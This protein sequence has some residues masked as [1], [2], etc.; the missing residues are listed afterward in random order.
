MDI[1]Y[2]GNRLLNVDQLSQVIG[3]APGTIRN[4][5][6]DATRAKQLPPRREIPGVA[7]VLFSS[8][9]VDKWINGLPIVSGSN[10]RQSKHSSHASSKADNVVNLPAK[11][12]KRRGRPT[13]REAMERQQA[14]QLQ[15]FC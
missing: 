4:M 14:I 9:D 11:P 7:S 12:A 6:S 13:I 3:L 5:L 1:Q 8:W 2:S 10:S 15:E